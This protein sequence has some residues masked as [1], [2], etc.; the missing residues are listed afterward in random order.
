MAQVDRAFIAGRC[1]G[2]GVDAVL[3]I[4]DL[5]IL[6][7]PYFLYQDLSTDAVLDAFDDEKGSTPHFPGLSRSDLARIRDRQLGIYERA[8]G[9]LT[10][11][12]WLNDRLVAT[13]IPSTRVHTVPPGIEAAV[14]PDDPVTPTRLDGPCCSLLVHRARFHTK[15]GDLVVQAFTQLRA[16]FDP[17]LTLTVAGPVHWPMAGPP[18]PGVAFLGPVSQARVGELDLSHDLL[19]MPSRLEGF[20]KVFAEAQCAGLPAIA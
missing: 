7:R 3:Q 14:G 19:V 13:G 16:E 12:Q 18:P 6:D 20:G 15:G 17:G 11:S 9:I 1:A 8:T 10:M 5:A 2:S 4:G